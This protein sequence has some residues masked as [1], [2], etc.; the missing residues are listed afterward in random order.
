MYPVTAAAT[1]GLVRPRTTAWVRLASRDEPDDQVPVPQQRGQFGERRG[2]GQAERARGPGGEA[3]QGFAAGRPPQPCHRD[4]QHHEELADHGDEQRGLQYATGG[5]RRRQPRDQ[6]VGDDRAEQQPPADPEPGTDHEDDG[7][8]DGEAYFE[9]VDLPHVDQEQQGDRDGAD[10]DDR[11][12]QSRDRHRRQRHDD[13]GERCPVDIAGPSGKLWEQRA[14]H[15]EPEHALVGEGGIGVGSPG[16]AAEPDVRQVCPACAAVGRVG[17]A[18]SAVR[19]DGRG[20]RGGRI[21]IAGHRITTVRS[22]A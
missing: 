13:E 2:Q 3:V 18:G 15:G 22:A 7:R 11:C 9:R 8:R 16:R 14:D 20:E 10:G 17:D 5:Q 21:V 4:R 19:A 6:R 12:I 1:S